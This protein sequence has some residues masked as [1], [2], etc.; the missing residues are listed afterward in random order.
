MTLLRSFAWLLA[1]LFFV[2]TGP[3]TGVAQTSAQEQ[4]A[5]AVVPLTKEDYAAF[6]AVVTRAENAIA[7]NRASDDAM[8]I[9]RDDLTGWR[10]RFQVAQ[11][12]NTAVIQ[13]LQEQLGNLGVLAEGEIEAP[14]VASQRV[15]LNKRLTEVTAPVKAAE[16]AYSRS[17][18]LVRAVDRIMRERQA[19]QLLSLSPSPLN[20]ANWAIAYS[21]VVNTSIEVAKEV[22]TAW[23][24]K[25]KRIQTRENLPTTILLLLIALVVLFRGRHW[26]ERASQA[27]LLTGSR[28]TAGR[29]LVSFVLS[30]GQV[31]VPLIGVLF[32]S[33]AILSMGLIGGR[34]D[35]MFANL[36]GM[37]LAFFVVRWLGQRHFPKT[38]VYGV[39][40]TLSKEKRRMGRLF[41]G[42]LGLSL[43]ILSFIEGTRETEKW[44]DA[45]A[46]VLQFPFLI[47]S[48]FVMIRIAGLMMAHVRAGQGGEESR[49]YGDRLVYLA[50]RGLVITSIVGV[51]AAAVGYFNLGSGLV[52]PAANS[53]CL[54]AFLLILQRLI[55]VIYEILLGQGGAAQESDALFPVLAGIILVILSLPLF[56]LIWGAQWNDLTEVWAQF[57]KGVSIGETRISP[58]IFL[59]LVVVFATGFGFTRL[60]QGT[61]KNSVL[62]KTKIDPGGQNAIVSGLGYVGIFLSALI[63]VTSAGIDLSSLAI[64]AGALSVGIGFGL[65]NIVSNFVSGIILLIER[66]ISEGDWI[67]VGGKQGYV[68]D[69]SVRSTRIETFDRTDVIVPNADFVSGMVTNFTRGKTVGRVIVPVGVAYG[70]DTRKVEQILLKIAEAQPMVLANPAPNVIFMGFGAD[71]LNFEIRAILR[72]VNWSMAVRSEI[73]H[74]IAEQFAA[75]GIEIPFA[76][77]DITIK[78]PEFVLRR[79]AKG[80]QVPSEEP[81][82]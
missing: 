76:Q 5:A 23:S 55:S 47:I 51:L 74:Q 54:F 25:S 59:T 4:S 10:D 77:R 72:D 30:L 32:L 66:P 22:E 81:E 64:V 12:Q 24:S 16:L 7:T 69:I 82:A 33:K 79:E 2:A 6:E 11:S 70:T 26:M 8:L 20:P 45:A 35:V 1:V 68:R 60:L 31:L 27:V 53:L 36:A 61:L 50:A 57:S 34:G 56:A 75:Q 71:S 13:A 3:L 48:A 49:N 42:A 73:N 41:S 29:W 9:L 39:P 38:D 43:G 62:P 19:G 52:F 15:A 37:I 44:P 40:L 28:A 63:A 17:D 67:E 21:A 18:G 80:A 78:N 65:Q 58:M 14:E 46:T